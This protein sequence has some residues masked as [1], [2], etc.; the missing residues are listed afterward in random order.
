VG[1]GV[2]GDTLVPSRWVTAIAA[3]ALLIAWAAATV[4]GPGRADP[5]GAALRAE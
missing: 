5:V 4:G 1:S 2:G 3:A